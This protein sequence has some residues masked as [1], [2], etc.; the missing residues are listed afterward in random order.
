MVRKFRAE[1]KWVVGEV[2]TK[3]VKW[4]RKRWILAQKFVAGVIEAR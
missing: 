2:S 3:M 1:F 4:R